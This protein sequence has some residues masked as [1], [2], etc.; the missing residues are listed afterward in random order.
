MDFWPTWVLPPVIPSTP[1]LNPLCCCR[2]AREQT[3]VWILLCP[4]RLAFTIPLVSV[5]LGQQ[6]RKCC[7]GRKKR[8]WLQSAKSPLASRGCC[9]AAVFRLGLRLPST[10]KLRPPPEDKGHVFYQ[11]AA[12]AQGSKPLCKCFSVCTGTKIQSCS[13][14]LAWEAQREVQFAL[15]ASRVVGLCS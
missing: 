12:L 8:A 5:R 4:D 1:Q 13:P 3:G 14:H 11:L 10:G 2:E 15:G 7:W 6:D 9:G